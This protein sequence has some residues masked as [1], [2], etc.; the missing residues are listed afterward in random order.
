VPEI[1]DI[2]RE[3]A[4]LEAEIRRLEA[5]YNMFFAGRLPRPPA[6][7]RRRVSQMVRRLDRASLTNYA[8]RF[9]FSTLQ[10]RFVRFTELW[11]RGLRAREEGRPGPFGAPQK[12]PARAPADAETAH[13]E[14]VI[15]VAAFSDP[16]AEGAKLR[17]L[18]DHLSHARREAGEEPVPFERFS[19]GVAEQVRQLKAKGAPE[20]AVRVSMKAGKV[21]V[22]ARGLRGNSS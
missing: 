18:Y 20:V 15:H 17:E 8:E 12:T 11:D 6:E 14:Q 1:P 19:Q 16:A 2:D 4:V 21:T 22:T 13:D 3:L 9:R 5:E 7:T 10:A